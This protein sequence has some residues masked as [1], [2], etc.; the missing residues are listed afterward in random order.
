MSWQGSALQS[1]S[2]S[3]ADGDF[4]LF[5]FT[6]LCLAFRGEKDLES[7]TAVFYFLS[8]EMTLVTSTHSLLAKISHIGPA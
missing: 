8:P 5:M 6:S 3:Q 2:R 4:T 1:H 7:S